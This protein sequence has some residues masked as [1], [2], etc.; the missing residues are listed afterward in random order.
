MATL[1]YYLDRRSV[2][3]DGTSPVKVLVNVR[4]TNFMISTG[5]DLLPTQWNNDK[6]LIVKHPRK[7]FLNTYLTEMIVKGDE[8]LM[9]EQKKKGA[10]LSVIQVKE[11][12]SSLFSNC[13]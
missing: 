5:I 9:T 7:A 11:L 2:K 13:K 1:S 12:M 4:Q 3:K 10:A 6:K 8:L